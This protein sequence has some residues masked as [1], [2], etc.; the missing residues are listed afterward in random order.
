M[1]YCAFQQTRLQLHFEAGTLVE[2]VGEKREGVAVVGG[3][4]K[5]DGWVGAPAVL[6]G[7]MRQTPTRV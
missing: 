2:I 7:F 3:G 5:G 4:W 6:S 1:S